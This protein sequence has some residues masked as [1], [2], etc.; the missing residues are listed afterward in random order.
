LI[1]INELLYFSNHKPLENS[2]FFA[3]AGTWSLWTLSNVFGIQG[4]ALTVFGVLVN[5]AIRNLN[6]I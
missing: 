6:R 5:N 1:P 4:G 2:M 3:G